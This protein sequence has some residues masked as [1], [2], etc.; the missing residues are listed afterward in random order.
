MIRRLVLVTTLLIG[1]FVVPSAL[2]VSAQYTGLQCGFVITPSVVSPGDPVTVVGFG[3]PA[4][5]TVTVSIDGIGVVGTGTAAND[6]QGSFSISFTAPQTAG[7]FNVTIACGDTNLSNLLTVQSVPTSGGGNLPATG[8]G[9][10]LPL[11][12]LGVI[13]LVGGAFLVLA[14]R[15]RR[16]EHGTASLPV[17]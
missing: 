16:E 1:L 9:D 4:N 13:L 11:T 14:V 8:S 12:R 5:S 3:A 17:S 7:D 10:A 2:P 6:G 15:R